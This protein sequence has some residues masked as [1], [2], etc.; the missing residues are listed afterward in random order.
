MEFNDLS[1]VIL[2]CAIEVHKHLG[3]GLLESAYEECLQYELLNKGLIVER[4]KPVPIV[5]KE[6]RLEYGYRLDL[7]VN[8]EI[9]VEAKSVEI[10]APL[11]VVQLLT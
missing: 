11:H 2:G 5:Y 8:K 4:Q 3:A 9:I 7:L 10:L 1:G 6:I